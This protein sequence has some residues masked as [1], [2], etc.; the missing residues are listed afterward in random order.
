MDKKIKV[1]HVT[2]TMNCGGQETF[3]M[4]IFRNIDREKIQ[5]DFVVHSKIKAHYDDEIKSLGGK[6]YRITPISKNPIKHMIELYK[7]LKNNDYDVVHRHTASSIVFIDTL[8]A[9]LVGIKKIIAHS[10]NNKL[11]KQIFLSILF[12]PLLNIS[13]T[14]KFACS[15]SAGTWLFGKNKDIG[16]IPNGIDLIKYKF[17]ENIRDKY[18]KELNIENK[19]VLGHVGRFNKQKNH[20]FLIDIFNEVYQQN[21]NYVLL[22]IGTGELEQQ[23][24]KKVKEL[25]IEN[26]V[27]FLGIR[28]DVNNLMQAMDIFLFPSIYEGLG[29]VLLEAQASALQCIVSENIQ[30]EAIFSNNVVK[31]QLDDVNLWKKEI[32]NLKLDFNRNTILNT[33]SNKYSIE[34][35][36]EYLSKIYNF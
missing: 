6:I 18:R 4:N 2:G 22:L 3:I 30:E 19:I 7:I 35:T 16:V 14:H 21:K 36:I 27:K 32:L 15:N 5:F 31:I 20:N 12:R 29:I 11:Q 17:N 26:S 34:N 28:N 8:I 33:L 13:T 9:K 24:Q 25:N 23:I 1:L 10:H